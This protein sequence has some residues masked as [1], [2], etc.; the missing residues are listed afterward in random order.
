AVLLRRFRRE[1][2]R[3]GE[4]GRVSPRVT[5]VCSCRLYGCLR[6]AATHGSGGA[7]RRWLGAACPFGIERLAQ[8]AC[9]AEEDAIR[10]LFVRDFIGDQKSFDLSA[11]LSVDRPPNQRARHGVVEV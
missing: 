10:L 6:K 3:C 8:R 4:A 1:A 5:S 11:L 7:L 2:R 9:P